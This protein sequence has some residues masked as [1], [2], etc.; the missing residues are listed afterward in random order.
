MISY[1]GYFVLAVLCEYDYMNW[2]YRFCFLFLDSQKNKLRYFAGV[3]QAG[4]AAEWVH[5]L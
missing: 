2:G 1:W 4:L 3:V 5:C